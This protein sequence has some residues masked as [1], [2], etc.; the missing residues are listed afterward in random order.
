MVQGKKMNRY[1]FRPA[2]PCTTLTHTATEDASPSHF[3]GQSKS[4]RPYQFFWLIDFSYPLFYVLT[5]TFNSWEL[6]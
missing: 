2:V 6:K 4:I 3:P 1:Y 5:L